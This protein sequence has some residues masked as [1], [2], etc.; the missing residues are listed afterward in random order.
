[1]TELRDTYGRVHDYLRI[2]LTE[3]CNLRCFYCMPEEGVP[4]Q[5]KANYL[6]ADEVL[7]LAS[8]AVEMGVRKIR[9]T[10]GEPLLRK[11]IDRI[12]E[13]LSKLPVDLGITTNAILLDRHVAQIQELGIKLNISLDSLDPVRNAQIVKR[14]FF[15]RIWNNLNLAVDRGLAPKVN[16]VLIKGVND[17]E[18]IPFVALGKDRQLSVRFIE[19]MPFNG[20]SWSRTHCVDDAD[21]LHR[22]RDHFGPL[23]QLELAPHYTARSYQVPGFVGDFGLISTVTHPFCSTCNRIRLTADGKLKNCLFSVDEIDILGPLRRGE[24][25]GELFQ[26]AVG[27]KKWSRGG[28]DFGLDHDRERAMHNRSMIRIGG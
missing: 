8:K 17:D 9:L 21:V 4:L 22:I 19:F 2:S 16:V 6:T 3:R 27:A 28:L 10:G 24:P 25:V 14:D 20:N 23:K 15:Q 11:D 7:F 26:L 13:G 12:L 1:M 5:P 18:I